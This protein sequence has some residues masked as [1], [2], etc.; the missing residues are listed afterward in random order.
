MFQL[1]TEQADFLSLNIFDLAPMLRARIS[2]L[3][4]RH[5]DFSPRTLA[6]DLDI[7]LRCLLTR[8]FDSDGC[9]FLTPGACAREAPPSR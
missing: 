4:P 9:F 7:I 6:R 3:E 1:V 8:R 5:S 2:Q